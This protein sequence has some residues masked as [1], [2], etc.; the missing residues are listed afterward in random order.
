MDIENIMNEKIKKN[1]AKHPIQQS[2]SKS[3]K[4]NDL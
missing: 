1:E 3:D 2:F 4:Y